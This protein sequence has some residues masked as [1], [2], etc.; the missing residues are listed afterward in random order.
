MADL[1][2]KNGSWDRKP[3]Y[4]CLLRRYTRAE[5][6]T[7][8]GIVSRTP[9]A[10]EYNIS[11][12]KYL[13]ESQRSAMACFTADS[14][15]QNASW[16]KNSQYCCLFSVH[17]TAEGG[18]AMEWSAGSEKLI[19]TIFHERM[20]RVRLNV[21]Q[22]PVLRLIQDSKAPLEIKNRFNSACFQFIPGQRGE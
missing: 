8:R 7:K 12:T 2:Q 21:R 15:Q 22:W 16:R 9:N 20:T 19:N 3:K 10:N 11:R 18:I 1:R 5:G 6:E 17:S 13:H 14:R 4:F